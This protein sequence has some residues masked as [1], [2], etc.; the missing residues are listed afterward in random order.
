MTDGTGERNGAAG[1]AAAQ[2]SERKRGAEGAERQEQEIEAFAR[3]FEA[4]H[5]GVYIGLIRPAST[6][7]LSA[8]PYLKLM[9]GFAPETP[10]DEVRPF[11]PER[12]VDPQARASFVDRLAH[13][14]SLTDYLLRIRRA[15]RLPG[16]KRLR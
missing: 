14:R 1:D 9:F 16:E 13:D 3:L 7:T 5:E 8:N 4:V 11:D 10:V 6:A 2:W 15:D 12:F